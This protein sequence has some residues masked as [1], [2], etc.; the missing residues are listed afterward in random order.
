VVIA[1]EVAARL[2]AAGLTVD[3]RHRDVNRPDPR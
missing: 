2:S 1:V 3:V